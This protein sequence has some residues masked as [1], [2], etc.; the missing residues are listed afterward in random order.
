MT[1]VDL[2]LD[3]LHLFLIPLDAVFNFQ[4]KL[5]RFCSSSHVFEAFGWEVC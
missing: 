3:A 2:N 4:G 5:N 1:G